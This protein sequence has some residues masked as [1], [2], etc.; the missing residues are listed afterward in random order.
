MG[1]GSLKEKSFGKMKSFCTGNVLEIVN[2][3]EKI[4]QNAVYHQICQSVFTTIV[5]T[6][7]YTVTQWVP[8]IPLL[9][10]CG[11]EIYWYKSVIKCYLHMYSKLLLKVSLQIY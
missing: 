4:W 1:L 3:D 7:Q 11:H 6:L 9:Q 8:I 10:T 5:F 2:I